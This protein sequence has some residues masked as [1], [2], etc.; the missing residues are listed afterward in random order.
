MVSLQ[1]TAWMRALRGSAGVARPRPA[2]AATPP[3]ASP[4]A[5]SCTGMSKSFAGAVRE[6]PACVVA[7]A[8]GTT[9]SDLPKSRSNPTPTHLCI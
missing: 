7:P 5:T 6:A 3:R 9:G 2:L 8:V 4:G 1:P